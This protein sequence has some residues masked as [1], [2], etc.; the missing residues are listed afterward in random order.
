[1]LSVEFGQGPRCL[2]RESATLSSLDLS[3]DWWCD[4]LWRGL[5]KLPRDNAP[6][7]LIEWET[8]EYYSSRQKGGRGQAVG[9]GSEGGVGSRRTN[10]GLK[11][12]VMTRGRAIIKARSIIFLLAFCLFCVKI[13]L[14]CILYI[15]K[16]TLITVHCITVLLFLIFL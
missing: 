4:A 2:S 6:D 11:H 8:I 1:M 15:V 7:Q 9:I 13:Y 5:E 3:A 16:L 10:Q 14:R 12:D